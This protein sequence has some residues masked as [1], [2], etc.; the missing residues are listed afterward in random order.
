V[1]GEEGEEDGEYD[2]D[3]EDADDANVGEPTGRHTKF[4]E[5]DLY[6]RVGDCLWAFKDPRMC[7]KHRLR[8]FPANWVC[9]GPCK[10]ESAQGETHSSA[11]F[12]SGDTL[13]RHLE[14]PKNA[15]CMEA[16]LN[17]LD[18]KTIPGSG[19]A[20][21][22]PL[23][24]GLERPWEAPAFQLTDLKT[25]KEEERKISMKLRSSELPDSDVPASRR[26]R[27]K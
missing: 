11:T 17:L 13:K 21:L 16:V 9:P 1:P 20:W 2:Y 8:H 23:R 25:V 12:A 10:E 24:S 15:A 5:E 26:R 3:D 19:S 4:T 18:L 7:V 27:Y 22:A 6:C 14:C